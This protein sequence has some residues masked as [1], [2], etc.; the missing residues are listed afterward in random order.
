MDDRDVLTQ[1]AGFTDLLGRLGYHVEVVRLGLN[2]E[3]AAHR[4]RKIAPA[5]VVNL[6]ESVDGRDALQY[7]GPV[8]LDHLGIPYTGSPPEAVYLTSN[9]V[10]A[11]R[12]MERHAVATPPWLP[13]AAAAQGQQPGEAPWI[14][15]PVG[16]HASRGIDDESLVLSGADLLVRAAD[17][18]AGR[19]FVERYIE[20]REICVSLL[21]NG[22]DVDVLPPSEIDFSAY[23][24]GKPRIVGYAAKWIESTFEYR[25]S[26]RSH[27]FPAADGPLLER[28]RDIALR[29]WEVF[30]LRGYARVDFRVDQAGEP[31]VLEV[32]TNPCLSPDA[33]FAAAAAEAGLTL[34][35]VMR[36]IVDD[37]RRGL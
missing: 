24:A 20:G 16:E 34:E 5:L 19:L 12:T 29:C 17:P 27:V 26:V 22:S 35:H 9:K 23:P 28:V 25:C 15:K 8:I 6:V 36:R 31:W 21:A 4:L 33:G 14:V 10:L 18:A 32:N 30:D 1:A 3:A 37:A 2:L 13:L 7:L 11:K